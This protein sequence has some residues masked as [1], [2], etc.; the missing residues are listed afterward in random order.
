MIIWCI[1]TGIFFPVVDLKM[2][3]TDPVYMLKISLVH[4][5]YVT[6]KCTYLSL[7]VTLYI[8]TGRHRSWNLWHFLFKLWVCRERENMEE[9]RKITSTKPQQLAQVDGI[10][11][12]KPSLI[13]TMVTGILIVAPLL[14]PYQILCSLCSWDKWESMVRYLDD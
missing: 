10:T 9:A 13:V 8:V 1:C 6:S 4:L 5:L 12:L 7:G 11:Q 14:A 3:Q 2:L